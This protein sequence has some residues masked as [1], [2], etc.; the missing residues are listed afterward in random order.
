MGGRRPRGNAGLRIAKGSVIAFHDADDLMKQTRSADQFE[1]LVEHPEVDV[2]LGRQEVELLDG[3]EMPPWVKPSPLLEG[4][5]GVQLDGSIMARAD[6]LRRVDGFNAE[7]T[8]SEGL[9][10]LARLRD[11]GMNFGLVDKVIITRRVHHKNMSYDTD[12]MVKSFP[13]VLHA[14]LKRTR[15]DR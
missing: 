1:Y 11:A 2:V 14:H 7:L 8:Y 10:V 15:R 3:A 4:A 6:S 5:V 13:G 9:D 12:P